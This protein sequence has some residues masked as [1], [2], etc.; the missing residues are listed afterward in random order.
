VTR[1][2]A[3][4]RRPKKRLDLDEAKRLR[5]REGLSAVA[6]ARELEVT[7]HYLRKA[8]KSQGISLRPARTM[9]ERHAERLYNLWRSVR[10]RCSRSQ[11]NLYPRYGAKGYAVSPEWEDFWRFYDWAIAAGYRPG[12]NLEVVGRARRFSPTNCRWITRQQRMQRDGFP[13][14]REPKWMVSAFGETKSISAWEQDPRC[15]VSASLLRMRLRKGVHP[16]S[17]ITIRSDRGDRLPKDPKL[18]QP[19]SGP[20]R[21]LDWKAIIQLHV[22]DGLRPEAIAQRVGAN[23]SY[24]RKGLKQRGAWK[25]REPMLHGR[26]LRKIWENMRGRCEDKANQS[27]RYYGAR[28]AKVCSEWM[29]FRNFHKWGI[30]SGYEPGLCITRREGTRVYSPSNCRWAT[31]DEVRLRA[32]HEA[33]T[34]PPRWTFTAFGERKGPTEWS[35]DS[36]CVVSPTGLLYR[37]RGGW[38]PE[39]AITTPPMT[40]G[41][42]DAPTRTVTAFGTTKGITAWTRDRRCKVDLTALRERLDR[43]VRPEAAITT[44]PFKLQVP[45][46][47]RRAGARHSS[48]R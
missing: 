30:E 6:I 34:F 31:R 19:V 36:R 38:K 25:L 47:R 26:P 28:G 37:L 22:Q 17:A 45:A 35:R 11:H 29:E 9:A 13:S 2:Y 12:L 7:P 48:T 43:G 41:S 24:I 5:K 18:A 1:S 40:P 44:P 3:R 16:E 21:L 15:A 33:K 42:A 39:E 32:K 46:G 10:D 8:L 14:G 4:V 20:R 23:S 27:Y